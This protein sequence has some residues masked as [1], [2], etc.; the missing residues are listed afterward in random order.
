MVNVTEIIDDG[1]ET[2]G[3]ICKGKVSFDEFKKGVDWLGDDDIDLCP[4]KL[5]HTVARTVP[6][7][8]HEYWS[9][10]YMIPAKP[11]RGAYEATV[12]YVGG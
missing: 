8:Y 6:T 2:I 10:M 1:G 12:Y 9:V 3:Y 4:E 11:G 5:I 7:P